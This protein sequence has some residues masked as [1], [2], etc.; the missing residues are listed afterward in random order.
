MATLFIRQRVKGS[1]LTTGKIVLLLGIF[2]G[3]FSGT[4]PQSKAVF[5]QHGRS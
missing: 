5:E 4:W 3:A 1:L 2:C